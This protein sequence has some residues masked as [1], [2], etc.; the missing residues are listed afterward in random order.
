M[1]TLYVNYDTCRYMYYVYLQ[2]FHMQWLLGARTSSAL[3]IHERISKN[4]KNFKFYPS[5]SMKPVIVDGTI[6]DTD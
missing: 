6:A 2:V 3:E 1:I 5:N 4:E